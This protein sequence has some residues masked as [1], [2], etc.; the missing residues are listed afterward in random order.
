MDANAFGL[1]DKMIVGGMYGNTGWMA[2]AMYIYTP[3]RQ[4]APGWSLSGFYNRSERKYKDQNETIYRR[5]TLSS[6]AVQAGIMYAPVEPLSLG[7]SVSVEDRYL[8]AGED[9]L[10]PPDSGATIAAF[11]PS[12]DIRESNWDGY[13]LSEQRFSAD[14]TY[15]YGIDTASHHSERL[16]INLEQSLIPGFRMLISATLLYA[17]N[18]GI[19][20]ENSPSSVH[21]NILPRNFFARSYAGFSGGLEKCLSKFSAGTLSVLAA[22]EGAL[23]EG[24]VL[25]PCWDQGIFGSIRLYLSRV[26]IPA[27]GLGYGY[28]ISRRQSTFVFSMGMAF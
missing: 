5:F 4:G 16:R 25:G 2:M 24:P 18:A 1:N 28:N 3:D 8:S 7:F 22:W 21:I 12:L 27:L 6:I 11:N 20:F 9:V 17:G 13:F 14:Y 23:S 26:A 19:L 10:N 15:T